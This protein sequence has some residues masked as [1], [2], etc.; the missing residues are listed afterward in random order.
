[1]PPIQAVARPTTERRALLRLMHL[2]TD[3][4]GQSRRPWLRSA[5]RR[6]SLLWR[7]RESLCEQFSSDICGIS[8]HEIRRARADDSRLVPGQVTSG[9]RWTREGAPFQAWRCLPGYAHECASSRAAGSW[10]S[11]SSGTVSTSSRSCT[12]GGRIMMTCGTRHGQ[13]GRRFSQRTDHPRACP[14]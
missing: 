1:M 11:T 12:R 9:L 10:V 8:L 6:L 2:A 7:R 3:P 5:A 4:P 14:G 13:C